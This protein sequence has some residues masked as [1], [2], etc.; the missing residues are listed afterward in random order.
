MRTAQAPLALPPGSEIQGTNATAFAAAVQILNF[1]SGAVNRTVRFGPDA[2]LEGL[3]RFRDLK[4]LAGRM[5]GDEVEVLLVHET[6]PVYAGAGLGF[7]EAMGKVPFIVSFS[8]APDETSALAHLILPDDTPYESWGDAEPVRG[9]RRLQQPTIRPIFDTRPLGDVL[10]ET[11]RA[12]GVGDALP[13]G[14][15]RDQLFAA[16]GGPA[17]DAALASGGDFKPAAAEPVAL[18]PSLTSLQFEPAQ[19][20]GDGALALVAYPSLHFYDGR[21]ARLLR[22]QEVPDAVTKS[23]WG[24]VAEIHPDTAAAL[25]VERGDVLRIRTEQGQL[26]LP[27]LPHE[28]VRPGVVAIQV[29]QG[30]QPIEPNLDPTEQWGQ[31]DWLGRREV[32]GVNVL[33]VLSGRLDPASGGLAWY[34][35]KV[36]VEKTGAHQFIAYTQATS[37]QEGRGIGQATT[38]AALRGE[39][40]DLHEQPHM[41][42]KPFDPAA[43]SAGDSP[44]RWGMSIDLDACTGCNACVAAC[45][46]ENNTPTIGKELVLKG[47][48]MSWIRLNRFVEHNGDAVEIRQIPMLCQH[49]GAAPCESVC[50]VFATYH[51]DEGLNVMVYNRCI[52]TR[53]CSNNC[54]YKVRRFNYLP[55]DFEIRAPENLALNP[56][57]TVRT[58]GV[59]EKCS[60]CVQRIKYAQDLKAGTDDVVADGEVVSA[61]QQACPS[62]AI[63]FGNLK[64][65]ESRVRQLLEDPR[66][67]YVFEHLYTRPAVS[68]LKSI[69]RVPTEGDHGDGGAHHG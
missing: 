10:L 69:R 63:T 13:T 38:L 23:T 3:H 26:E 64:D 54:P 59:M 2:N 62:Q 21:S 39:G 67:Y 27:A 30:H 7:A 19:L 42:V 6:N 40:E 49:C 22:L 55:Y 16:W 15:F 25:G 52:G 43:D 4:E 32:Y 44:Y 31:V 35:S 60:F 50:P 1:V 65:P 8:S 33:S 37:D 68:Y 58:K 5:R 46:Q 45:A 48:E 20:G 9:V 17:I 66:Q 41:E 61:C 29:G 12:L 34:S 51:S 14:S 56:D 57:V 18:G 47:R 53:Y 36:G 28:G 11:G 24:S